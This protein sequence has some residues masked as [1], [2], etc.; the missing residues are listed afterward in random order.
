MLF[1][2]TTRNAFKVQDHTKAI[3]CGKQLGPC[4]GNGE[5]F[6]NQPFNG[7]NKCRSN[8]NREGYRITMDSEGKSNLTNLKSQNDG[9]GE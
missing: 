5:L 4:F 8:V 2:L 6:A 3:Y 9:L 7:S 1:N